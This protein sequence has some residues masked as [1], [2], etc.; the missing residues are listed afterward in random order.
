[1]RFFFVTHLI[2]NLIPTVKLLTLTGTL[3]QTALLFYCTLYPDCPGGRIDAIARHVS[4][5][6]I[7]CS[8]LQIKHC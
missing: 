4:F 1:M 8:C 6:Q 7:T 3:I 2:L 5:V